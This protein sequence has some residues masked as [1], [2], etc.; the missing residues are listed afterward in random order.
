MIYERSSAIAVR[1]KIALAAMGL[2]RSRRP[3]R[4]EQIVVNQIARRGVVVNRLTCPKYPRS[5]RPWSRL[6]A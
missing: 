2:A 1:A 3:G 4:M 6:K 5:G